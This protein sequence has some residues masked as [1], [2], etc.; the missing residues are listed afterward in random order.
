MILIN[1][2]FRVARRKSELNWPDERMLMGGVLDLGELE[3]TRLSRRVS[4]VDE[5]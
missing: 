5:N 2:K 4:M 3:N 1:L